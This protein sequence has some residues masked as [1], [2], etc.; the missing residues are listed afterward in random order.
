MSDSQ[1]K[2]PWHSLDA[3]RVFELLQAN[4]NGLQQSEFELRLQKY[5]Y[6]RL[7]PPKRKSPLERFLHQFHNVLIYVLLASGV[8]PCCWAIGLTVA[9]FSVWY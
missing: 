8:V 4:E 9:S 7:R 2:T 1:E 6:N 5:G 3:A